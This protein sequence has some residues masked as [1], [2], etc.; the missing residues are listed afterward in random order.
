MRRR[1]RRVLAA[2]AAA[3]TV[4]ALVATVPPAVAAPPRTDTT[5]TVTAYASADFASSG[6]IQPRFFVGGL[7]GG[8]LGFI[9][10]PILD[11]LINPLMTLVTQLPQNI[12]SPIAQAVNSAGLQANNPVAAPAPPATFASCDAAG[13]PSSACFDIYSFKT[14]DNPFVTFKADQ[15]SGWTVTDTSTGANQVRAQS[16][17]GAFEFDVMGMPLIKAT[18]AIAEATCPTVLGQNATATSTLSGVS[19]FN[20]AIQSTR[21]DSVLGWLN[22]S[23][24]NQ[25][26]LNIGQIVTGTFQGSPLSVALTGSG[27]S[28]TVQLDPYALFDA[29]GLNVVSSLL[30]EILPGADIKLQA[31]VGPGETS[32]G[33]GYAKAWGNSFGID[34]SAHFEIGVPGLVTVGFEI[35]TGIVMNGSSPTGGNLLGLKI[36]YAACTT[37]NPQPASA[38]PPGVN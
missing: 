12:M 36:S 33:V 38:I 21:A 8:L 28:T 34:L 2:V 13:L 5:P 30:S 11:G 3:G 10:N 37:N 35:P 26:L 17:A 32:D 4:C 6:H 18:S 29:L 9:L 1:R 31:F 20:G 14:Q 24:F 25:T 23:A 16:H 15:T 7:V 19:M 22:L 27:L